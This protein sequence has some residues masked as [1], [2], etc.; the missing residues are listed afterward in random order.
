M[1]RFLLRLCVPTGIVALLLLTVACDESDCEVDA[2]CAGDL[3]EPDV[4]T[5]DN[6]QDVQ[7]DVVSDTSHDTSTDVAADIPSDGCGDITTDLPSDASKPDSTVAGECVTDYDCEGCESCI[8][9]DGS[10]KCVDVTIYAGVRQCYSDDDCAPDQV[11]HYYPIGRPQCGGGC[12]PK[13]SFDLHEWG[14]NVVTLEGKAD[15]SAAPERFYGAVVAKPVIYIYSTDQFDLDVRVDY[16]TG[17]SSETWPVVPNGS[18]VAWAGLHVGGT[19]C[20]TTSTPQPEILGSEEVPPL[21]IYDLPKWVVPDANCITWGDTITK[22]LFYTGPFGDYQPPVTATMSVGVK[23]D[24]ASVEITNNLGEALGPVIAMYRTAESSCMDPSYCPVH[25]ARIAWAV[26]QNVPTGGP[27]RFD[28]ELLDLHVEPSGPDDYPS[29]LPLLPSGWKDLGP[30]LRAALLQKGLTSAEA[31]VFMTAWTETMFGLL[32]DDAYWY[33][34]TYKNGG[35]LIYL[36]PDTR[37]ADMLPMTTVPTP[38]SSARAIVE[39]QQ[40]PVDLPVE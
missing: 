38:A 26:I 7:M 16:K 21:E 9:Q 30:T 24:Q 23:P 19:S 11:C 10:K 2:T 15:M 3:F 22:L 12:G 28:M 34:P 1:N 36:W 25:T 13:G 14:V 18:T 6:G 20:E 4:L 35:S 8:D 37:T 31:E 29:V 32:G 33:Y 40:V 39:Y 27:T 17:A 5:A